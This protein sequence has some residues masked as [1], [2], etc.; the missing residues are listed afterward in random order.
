MLP[1]YRFSSSRT[2]NGED[3]PAMDWTLI[4]TVNVG[5]PSRCAISALYYREEL[6]MC[7]VIRR[8]VALLT[9]LGVLVGAAVGSLLLRDRVSHSAYSLTREEL[10]REIKIGSNM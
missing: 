9:L 6:P 4:P 2:F 3:H 7:E 10:L 1:I 5:C 8:N